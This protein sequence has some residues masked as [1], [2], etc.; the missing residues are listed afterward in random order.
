MIAIYVGVSAKLFILCGVGNVLLV[1]QRCNALFAVTPYAKGK[2][3]P[4]NLGSRRVD[5]YFAFF[6]A[7]FNISVGGKAADMNTLSSLMVKHRSDAFR[8]VLKIPFVNKSCYLPG[9]FSAFYLRIN[10]VG[11][12]NK[13]DVPNGKQ[14][15][16]VFFTGFDITRKSRLRFTQHNVKLPTFTIVNQLAK[17]RTI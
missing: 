9:F 3:L 4:N 1:K 2:N 10:S 8:K 11:N 6:G 7:A 17:G 15:V 13:A 12:G 16:N 5:F 14:P